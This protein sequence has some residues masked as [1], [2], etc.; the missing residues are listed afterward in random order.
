MA[1]EYTDF[2]IRIRSLR[3]ETGMS[4]RK[5]CEHFGIPYQ[6]MTDWELGHRTAPDYVIRLLAYYINL[7]YC[8]KGQDQNDPDR[9]A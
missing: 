8:R 4:R 6:T 9:D 3:K 2:Q 5:F 7:N 1:K